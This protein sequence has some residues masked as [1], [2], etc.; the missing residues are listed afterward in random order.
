MRR[1]RWPRPRRYWQSPL[2]WLAVLYVLVGIVYAW[3]TP[4]LE[5]PDEEGHYGYIRYLREHRKLPPLHPSE[6]LLASSSAGW[7][8]EFK[9]PPLY[10]VV[11]AVLTSWLPDVAD[12]ER[13]LG[14]NPYTGFSVPGYR[15]DNRNIYLH[16]P[17]LTPVVLA[18]RLISLFFGLGTMITAYFLAA[19]LFVENSGAAL[20]TAAVVGFQ[21][22]FLYIA[23]AVNNDVAIAFFGTL[24]VTVLIYRLQKGNLAHFT[25]LLGTILGLAILTKA[26]GLIFFPLVGLALLFIH[27]GFRPA[28]FR[29]GV[30]IM[31]VALLI[32]GWWYARNAL[33]YGDPFTIGVHTS[34]SVEARGFWNRIG[35]DLSSIEYTFWANES[36]T[37]IS[38]IGLDRILIWWGR[39]SLGLLV[40]SC[41][42]NYRSTQTNMR[43][44]ILLLSWPAAFLFLLVVYWNQNCSWPFGRLLFPSI[45][46]TALSFIWGWQY[47]F[48]PCWRRLVLLLSAGTVVAIGILIPFVS[49]HSLFHPWRERQA[50]RVEHLVGTVYVNVETGEQIARLIG[51]NLLKPYAFPGTYFPL[52]LC[53]EPL[54]Q[55]DVPYAVLVQLLDFSQLAVYDSPGIWGRRETYPGL[56][57]LPTDRWALHKT[58]CDT[59]LTWVYP[60]TPTPLGAAIEVGFIGPETRDRLQPVDPQGHPMSL[61]FVGSVPI[62]SPDA[63]PTVEGPKLYIL[64]DAIGLNRVQLSRKSSITLTLTWQ[65]LR[66]VP[67]DATMFVHLR[68]RDGNILTQVD[69]QPLNGRFP[70]SYWL[71]GQIITD[72]VS[73]GPVPDTYDCVSIPECSGVDGPLTLN[74]GLYTWPS[75]QRL[76]VTDASGTPQQDNMIV[77]NVPPIP[78]QV[79][80]P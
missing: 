68:E 6:Q 79:T 22:K 73:L 50:E 66:P 59:L 58:F 53:W 61:A 37:Y 12:A 52:E 24:V 36:R 67:Y 17:D 29:D 38:P 71:P 9:Q 10:Y 3:V 49:L 40:L 51:Y 72:V 11:I 13:L 20:A 5:K 25:V 15:N 32:G 57:N 27:R 34:G 16:P 8:A 48:P 74:I 41:W 76:P 54:G 55:T 21:P 43:I 18:S 19:Q 35:Y 42:F 70:T 30:I 33:L 31:T 39:M 78:G 63:L 56:G 65:S 44:L 80:V 60:E 2:F 23:T 77:I 45:A 14:M 69:R 75:L 64:D 28:F 26:S 47:V 46:P 7:L 62:L 1:I 4:M